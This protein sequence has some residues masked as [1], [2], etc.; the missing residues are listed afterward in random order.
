M[1]VF[2]AKPYPE[3]GCPHEPMSEYFYNLPKKRKRT[4]RRKRKLLVVKK[5]W[6]GALTGRSW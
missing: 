5:Q 2:W 1:G 3:G 4:L 6:M